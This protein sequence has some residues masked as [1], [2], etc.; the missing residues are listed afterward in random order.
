MLSADG[1]FVIT[2]NGEIYNYRELR[3]E[4]K[5]KGHCVQDRD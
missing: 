1:R 4:L 5:G 2:F 3:E